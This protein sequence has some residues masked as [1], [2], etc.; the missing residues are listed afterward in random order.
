M[1]YVLCEL[2]FHVIQCHECV[3]VYEFF[4][5]VMNFMCDMFSISISWVI[6]FLFFSMS[7]ITLLCFF[8]FICPVFH[9]GG[10]KSIFILKN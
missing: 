10:K 8:W 3:Y 7:C 1:Y 6:C 5:Y 4:L 9:E 2:C